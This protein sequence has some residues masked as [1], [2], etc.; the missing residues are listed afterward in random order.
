M[1]NY[2]KS[3]ITPRT[4]QPSHPRVGRVR[5][6]YTDNISVHNGYANYKI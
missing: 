4:S 5:C 6:E 3:K 1:V 2:V